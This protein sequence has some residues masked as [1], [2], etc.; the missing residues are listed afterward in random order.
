MSKQG[1]LLRSLIREIIHSNNDKQ[2]LLEYVK[3]FK[4]PDDDRPGNKQV[5]LFSPNDKY[6]EQGETHGK[7]SHAIKHMSEFKP[8][9]VGGFLDTA[10]SKIKDSPNI[11]IVNAKTAE[12]IKD[13]PQLNRGTMLNTFD[14]IND[15]YEL[16]EELTEEEETI[17][18]IIKKMTEKY[19]SDIETLM[20]MSV[21]VDDIKDLEELKKTLSSNQVI[22]FT[23][24][25][26]DRKVTYYLDMTN[27]GLIA[28]RGDLIATMFRIDKTGANMEKVAKYFSG[29]VQLINENLLDAIKTFNS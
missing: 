4:S 28:K 6:L 24:L 8:D 18:D 12:P 13:N 1:H 25:Y 10:I 5:I 17:L 7:K 22:K 15:K 2:N 14:R 20:E 23:G 27:T 11:K 26:H 19:Q 3:F 21:D 9:I 16:E 29:T